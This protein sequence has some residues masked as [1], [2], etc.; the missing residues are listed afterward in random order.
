MSWLQDVFQGI[1]NAVTGRITSGLMNAPANAQINRSQ[2]HLR[3]TAPSTT[4][5]TQSLDERFRNA[6]ANPNP[7]RNPAAYTNIQQQMQKFK[8][9]N[10]SYDF[11]AAAAA[12]VRL[13]L[14]G[15][16]TT[17]LSEQDLRNAQTEDEA[18]ALASAEGLRD[19]AD[20]LAGNVQSGMN[21]QGQSIADQ[22]GQVQTNF[23]D[24]N[25]QIQDI[26]GQANVMPGQVQAQNLA[27]AANLKAVQE[28]QVKDLGSIIGQGLSQ[29]A[30]EKLEAL[31]GIS[32][33]MA[34]DLSAST[35]SVRA[36]MN[37][38]KSQILSNPNLPPEAKAKLSSQLSM[39]ASMEAANAAAPVRRMYRELETTTRTAFA[40]VGA[41]FSGAAATASSS[42]Y[43][44]QQNTTGQ[45]LSESDRQYA[46]SLEAAGQ[47]NTNLTSI[48][49]N[50]EA[51]RASSMAT[52]E[53]LRFQVDATGN[54]LLSALLPI[55][56]DPYILDS[57][58]D[59]ATFQTSIELATLAYQ[60]GLTDIGFDLNQ[61]GLDVSAGNATTNSLL[62]TQANNAASEAANNTDSSGLVGGAFS[63]GGD[64]LTAPVT[65]GGSLVGNMFS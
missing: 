58:G 32:D 40:K 25:T 48:L 33:N 15:I 10:G 17:Q 6:M 8:Q 55:Q 57:V 28:Q 7:N 44:N 18:K 65:G 3:D 47:I 31:K 27:S 38:Q 22:Q 56:A 20:E 16:D 61:L 23:Q 2:G 24:I 43:S 21:E 4:V 29:I 13:D 63:L 42:L 49:Q 35:A 45:F 5:P 34:A 52:L 59:Q 19:S 14:L 64:I 54:Q 26:R 39:Q 41:D 30:G 12:G 9:P 46:A 11:A 37:A 50:S 53:T 1:G 51:T 36:N 60:E 62:Q